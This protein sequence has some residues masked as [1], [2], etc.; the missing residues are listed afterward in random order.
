MAGNL[1][2]G[3]VIIATSGA[4][5]DGREIKKEWLTEMA[6]SYNPAFYSAKIWPDHKRAFGS[7]GK[8]LALK[9]EPATTPGLEGQIHLMGIL[10]PSDDLVWANKRGQYVHTSIEVLKNFA[11]KGF[12]YL[13]GLAATDTPASLGTSELAFNEQADK[14]YIHGNELDL[15]TAAEEKQPGSL[16]NF[17]KPKSTTTDQET[18]M[19]DE[20]FA[21]LLE[22]H[23]QT[24]QAL[25]AL[26][27]KFSTQAATQPPAGTAGQEQPAAQEFVSA[28]Q[29][30]ELQTTLTDALTQFKALSD[31]FEELS[32]TPAGATKPGDDE[33]QQK[34]E[35]L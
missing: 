20:Q 29:F 23:K 13:G 19:K 6:A 35:L 2:T 10:A 17:L 9:T 1:K 11:G 15:S 16:F 24:N 7:Q 4:T 8:V 32:K 22:A 31:K 21:A 26:L 28:Q 27:E 5:I 34:P 18:D 30:G 12:A 14:F 25:T 3:W 33:G